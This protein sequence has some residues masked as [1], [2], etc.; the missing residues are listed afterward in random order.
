MMM[1]VFYGRY[2]GGAAKTLCDSL[3]AAAGDGRYLVRKVSAAA[4]PGPGS[5][6]FITVAAADT[7]AGRQSPAA[8][9]FLFSF[10][11]SGAAT[12]LPVFVDRAGVAFPGSRVLAGAAG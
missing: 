4:A 12:N 5:S 1:C 10:C 8:G 6:S 2:A 11:G 3:V 9:K 7:P